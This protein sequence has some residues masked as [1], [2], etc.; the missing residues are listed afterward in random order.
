MIAHEVPDEG[1]R[2]RVQAWFV[3]ACGWLRGKAPGGAVLAPHLLNEPEPH[4]IHV[5]NGTLGAQS[6]LAS[7]ANLLP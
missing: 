2:G 1:M 3:P 5:G 4:A 6:P 7:T